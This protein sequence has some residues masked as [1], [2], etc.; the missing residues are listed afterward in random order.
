MS[1]VVAFGATF[2]RLPMAGLFVTLAAYEAA[3]VLGRWLG[4]PAW[5]NPVL[6]A[7][8]LV[9]AVLQLT[10][11]SYEV[12]FETAKLVHLLLGPAVVA[13]AVP[14]YANL[15]TIQRSASAIFCGVVMGAVS[16]AVSAVCI[17]WALGASKPVI[18]SVA[19]KSVTTAIAIGISDQIGGLPELTA[20]LVIITGILGAILALPL[21]RLSGLHCMRAAG[22][23]AGVAGHGIGTARVLAVDETAGAFGG[24]GM[25]LCGMFTAMVMPTVMPTVIAL[26]RL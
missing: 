19:P 9:V 5:A 3:L 23:A 11:T 26:L 1:I 4:S 25:G 22:L 2:F 16:A 6:L 18:L 24:L 7:I 8:A 17:A 12:Y 13:L 10:G 14:L 21:L 20:V 15:R